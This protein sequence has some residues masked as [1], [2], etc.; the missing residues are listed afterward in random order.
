MCYKVLCKD[1]NRWTWAGCGQHVQ[2]VMVNIPL[3]QRC[4]CRR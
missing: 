3:D 2:Q 1:C 4:I